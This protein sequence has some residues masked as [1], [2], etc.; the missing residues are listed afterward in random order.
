LWAEARE[1]RLP[2]LIPATVAGE[3]SHDLSAWLLG[4]CLK[5][6]THY[7]EGNSVIEQSHHPFLVWGHSNGL[8]ERDRVPDKLRGLFG[9]PMLF[10]QATGRIGSIYLKSFVRT[11]VMLGESKIV[12]QG[13][14]VKQL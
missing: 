10:K 4:E 3:C 6:I 13:A 2:N 7:V 14:N 8:M 12:K 9:D 11:T 1:N 5:A